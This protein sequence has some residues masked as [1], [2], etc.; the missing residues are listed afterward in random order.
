MLTFRQF[1]Q[2]YNGHGAMVLV[3][4]GGGE[5]IQERF[6]DPPAPYDTHSKIQLD[7]RR[8]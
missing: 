8:G 4:D 2:L 3:T 6:I 1:P 5:C 7:L